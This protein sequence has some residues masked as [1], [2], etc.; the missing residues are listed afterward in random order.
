MRDKIIISS[1]A[2]LCVTLILGCGEGNP[3]DKVN[4]TYNVACSGWDVQLFVNDQPVIMSQEQSLFS[5]V[6]LFV[7][8][9]KN[10]VYI[11]A[12]ISPE[13]D[14]SWNISDLDIRFLKSKNMYNEEKA[15]HEYIGG[16]YEESPESGYGWENEFEFEA[17]MELSWR[18]QDSEDIKEFNETDLSP[19]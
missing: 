16:I 2:F 11:K 10:K 14:P 1:I 9:G 17:E 5:D 3:E 8:N 4:Y 15:E 13:R 19:D 12:E 6:S 7:V 18:W